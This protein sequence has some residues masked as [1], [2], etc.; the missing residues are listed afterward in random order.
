MDWRRAKTILIIAFLLLDSF[1]GYQL[2]S[3]RGS[4]L[5][6]VGQALGSTSSFQDVLKARDIKLNVEAPTGTPEMNYLNIKY[7]EFDNRTTSVLANQDLR[8]ISNT[9]ESRFIHPMPIPGN[10]PKGEFPKGL[11]EQILYAED[12]VIDKDL[13]NST[14]LIYLQQ[15]GNYPFFGATL[16]LNQM[17]NK[18]TGYRQ[19]HFQ[20][21]NKGSGKKVISS[22]AA[23]RTLIESGLI[24][25]GETIHSIELG[26]YGHTYDADIQVIAPVWRIIHGSGQIQYVNGITGVIEKNPALPKKE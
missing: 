8:I 10:Q 11:S 18:T 24:H 19:R 3:S 6:I 17:D 21:V 5:E 12:Y 9:L 16:E 20:V 2:W 14:Q 7:E 1:L 23:T 13:S 4:N 22:L 15:W 26:Y 25:N